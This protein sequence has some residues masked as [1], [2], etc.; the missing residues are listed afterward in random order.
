M[1]LRR[2]LSALL[3]LALLLSLLTACGASSRDTVSRNTAALTMEAAQAPV[4]AEDAEYDYAAE[5]AAGNSLSGADT[6]STTAL[7]E[8]R[9][10]IITMD[11]ELETEDLD[12]LLDALSTDITSLSG[13]IEDQNLHNGSTYA[14]RRYRSANLT[15][16]IPADSTEQFTQ[17]VSGLANVVSQNL[18][19][20]D[21]TLQYTATASRVTALETEETRLLELLS[22]AESMTDLLEIESRLTEVRYQLENYTSQL[23]LYNNQV[24]YATI[25]L[26]I[27]EVQE[28]TPVEE[29]SLSQRISTTFS[30]SLED[31]G[32][33][34][35]DLLVWLLG[36]SPYLLLYLPLA[37]VLVVLVR[38]LRRRRAKKHPTAPPD[39]SK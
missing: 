19:R 13:Y 25:Y 33:G 1:K 7:P 39:A 27:D 30:N 5:G 16:R 36:N 4:M 14:T 10:W 21:I 15:V 34:V 37:A 11:M 9:K 24:D 17:C 23:R 3:S 31:L 6:G 35:L 22:Q 2:N 32:D 8:N 20:E 12:A 26:N 28:Y 29:P 18:S 38:R